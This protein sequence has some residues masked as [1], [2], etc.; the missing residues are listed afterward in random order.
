MSM[1]KKALMLG[2]CGAALSAA[3]LLIEKKNREKKFEEELWEVEEDDDAEIQFT[4]TAGDIDEFEEEFEEL[5]ELEVVNV[6]LTG[7]RTARV[8]PTEE[9]EK[10]MLREKLESV[11]RF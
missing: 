8:R 1:G 2:I 11:I 7:P 5:P 9:E 4:M 10:E 3:V 6:V